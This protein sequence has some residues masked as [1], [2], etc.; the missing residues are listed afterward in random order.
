MSPKEKEVLQS[1]F[2][3]LYDQIYGILGSTSFTTLLDQPHERNRTQS[4]DLVQV[5]PPH[6]ITILR[7]V[8]FSGLSIQQAC[9]SYEASNR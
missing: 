7:R 9:R 1:T 4:V 3:A 5:V 6:L 8:G 2:R